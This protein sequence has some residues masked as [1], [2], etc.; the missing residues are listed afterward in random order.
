MPRSRTAECS[1]FPVNDE[2]RRRYEVGRDLLE[3]ARSGEAHLN[4]GK[5][6]D[7]S[8]A[9]VVGNRGVVSPPAPWGYV[10]PVA[11]LIALV[12]VRVWTVR[13]RGVPGLLC[14][15]RCHTFQRPSACIRMCCSPVRIQM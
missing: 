13:H 1:A 7:R 12:L 15:Y 10:F 5:M 2:E 6:P 4:K 8:H 3:A 11:A 9:R 14:V